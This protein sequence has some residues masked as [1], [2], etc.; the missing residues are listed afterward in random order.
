MPTAV[1]IAIV[2]GTVI[3]ACLVYILV[4]RRR[5]RR[6]KLA[7]ATLRNTSALVHLPEDADN[8]FSIHYGDQVLRRPRVIEFAIVSIGGATL[9]KEDIDIPPK[10]KVPDGKIVKAKAV[11]RT[12]NGKSNYPLT[13]LTVSEDTVTVP[14]MV[15]NPGDA[16]VVDLVVDEGT[17]DPSLSMH[18]VGFT[19]EQG[20]RDILPPSDIEDVQRRLSIL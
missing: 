3:V 12:H 5:S 1:I 19:I 7:W 11:L 9:R 13:P 15:M 6:K 20:S 14:A 16:I 17:Q 8:P 10:L 18:V 4:E 2:L